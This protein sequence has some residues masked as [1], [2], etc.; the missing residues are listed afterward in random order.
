VEQK[1][2]QIGMRNTYKK[3]CIVT[4]VSLR[5]QTCLNSCEMELY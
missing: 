1:I 4:A 3:L 2:P 5:N